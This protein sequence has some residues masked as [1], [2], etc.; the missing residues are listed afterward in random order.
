MRAIFFLTGLLA[1]VTAAVSIADP[2]LSINGI[3]FATRAYW[4]RLASEALAEVSGSPC[5]FAAFGTVIVNHTN[6]NGLGDLVCIGVNENS[7]TGNPSQHGK[8][9]SIDSRSYS[10]C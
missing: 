8:F 5:P 6:I 4:M 1:A 9:C 7:Q 2:K 3:S 10:S